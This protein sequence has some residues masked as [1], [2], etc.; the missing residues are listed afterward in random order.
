MFKYRNRT[1][2][3]SVTVIILFLIAIFCLSMISNSYGTEIK[4]NS[5]NNQLDDDTIVVVNGTPSSY[6]KNVNNSS[7]N[8]VLSV[9]LSPANDPHIDKVRQIWVEIKLRYKE[10]NSPIPYEKI[11]MKV[12]NETISLKTNKNGNIDNYIYKSLRSGKKNFTFIFKASKFLK[13]GTNI[14]LHPVKVKSSYQLAK[15][16]NYYSDVDYNWKI[17]ESKKYK[18]LSVSVANFGL[19]KISRTYT[20]NLNK[21]KKLK[22]LKV[23]SFKHSKSTVEYNKRTK[24][25][26]IHFNL[27]RYKSEKS[28]GRLKIYLKNKS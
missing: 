17:L 5:S 15:G 9:E 20:I 11:Y 26:K 13:N 25:F 16:E 7:K 28:I 12:G 3:F 1:I 24:I 4:D 2:N 8:V 23:S 10:D 21:Y 27:P 19:G 6:I 14:Y 22:K 18:V